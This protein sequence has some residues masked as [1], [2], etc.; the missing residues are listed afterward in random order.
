[1]LL[2]KME[3]IQQT[4]LVSGCSPGR[5]VQMVN[6]RPHTYE[7][8]RLLLVYSLRSSIWP[9]ISLLHIHLGVSL[10][11]LLLSHSYLFV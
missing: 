6:T 10:S 2:S 11:K 8:Y 7:T 1:M 9:F 4:V 3:R 5:D